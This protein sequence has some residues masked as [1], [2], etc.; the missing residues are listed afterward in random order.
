MV[1]CILTH[2]EHK[3]Q[4]GKYFAYAPYVNEMNLWGVH[5]DAM[6]VVAPKSNF[7]ISPIHAAYRNPN[8]SFRSTQEFNLASFKGIVKTF[9]AIP[10]NC[11]TIFWAMKKADHIHLRCPGNI[12][13]L[14]CFVQILFP[15]K[16]K[17]AKYAGNWDPNA[18]QPW[19]YRLQKKLLN[20]TF[21]TRNMTVLVYGNWEGNSINCK[22][23]FTATYSENEMQHIV[24][25]TTK[26]VIRALFVGTLSSGKQPLYAIQCVEKVRA[27][28]CLIQ[29]DLCGEGLE[30]NKLEQYISDH[31]LKDFV[32]LK[33]NQSRN[34]LIDAYQSSH[35]LFLPSLSEGWPKAV[36]EA[37]FWGCLP[38]AT[39][40]SC[41][42]QMLDFGT[43]GCL[44]SGHI[45]EDAQMILELT[46]DEQKYFEMAT[47]AMQ[48]SRKFT[49]ERMQ[50]E[51][52]Q[53]L[54]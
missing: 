52:K 15:N 48:W 33:G 5:V 4:N 53:L 29:L 19:T 40:V 9:F 12:G 51:I 54:S 34:D 31:N 8:L 23:F 26:Q 36:A 41:V 50:S 43:R 10:F 39:K 35:F 37:M 47:A 32:N 49:I 44:L 3:V 6:V 13:L 7:S 25:R 14:A 16:R 30:R 2:V 21:L 11:W 24:P 18:E 27:L 42:P 28:G 22:P 1:F 46:S 17:T 38:M 20:N 45:E